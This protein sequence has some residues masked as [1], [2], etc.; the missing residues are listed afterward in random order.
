MFVIKESGEGRTL[1]IILEWTL[2]FHHQL[3]LSRGVFLPLYGQARFTN[4]RF[5]CV[6]RACPNFLSS[7]GRM[8]GSRYSCF[9]V[10]GPV[11]WFGYMV[12]LLSKTAWFCGWVNFLSWMIINLQVL[13][14][15]DIT[16]LTKVLPVVMYGCESWT[17]KAKHW[18]IDAFK[19]CCWGRLLG[20]PWIARRSN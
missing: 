16:L 9:V 2:L 11:S 18:R 1:F 6:L 8:W 15:R 4:Y 20:V 17:I 10:R 12:L 3:L 19:L 7:L 5:L 14:N 13:K